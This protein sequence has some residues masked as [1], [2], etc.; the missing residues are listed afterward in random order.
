MWHPRNNFMCF[1]Q[2]SH[3]NQ[4]VS[5]LSRELRH[6]MGLLHARLGPSGH[7]TV[8]AWPPDHP[9]PQLRP[10]CISPYLSGPPP[11]LQDTTF[12]EVHRPASVGTA[13]MGVSPADLRPSM[14]SP[15]P[16]EPDPLGP[17]PVPEA[18]SAT[19]SLMRHSFR[20]RSDTFH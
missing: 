3:L 2:I 17:S 13:E 16:S 1:Q 19:P 15:Y 12:A 8:S 20:S 11:D 4:E 9:G 18:S 14:L 7:P 10:P 6:M 5:Q